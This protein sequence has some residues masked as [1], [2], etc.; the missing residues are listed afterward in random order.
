MEHFMTFNSIILTVYLEGNLEGRI[1]HVNKQK[2]T[3]YYTDKEGNNRSVTKRIL[4][5]DRKATYCARQCIISGEVIAD[6][7][8]GKAPS[9]ESP[10]DWKKKNTTQRIYS[11]VE[12]F[13]EGYGVGIEVIEDGGE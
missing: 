4:F 13:D 10:R 9:W 6:W 11:Y 2:N 12:G 7:A 1:K 3:V 8:S 5:S